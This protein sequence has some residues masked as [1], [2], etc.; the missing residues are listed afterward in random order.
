MA[1]CL[2][3][4]K[5]ESLSSEVEQALLRLS[6]PPSLITLDTDADLERMLESLREVELLIV[7]LRHFSVPPP[8]DL[9]ILLLTEA[10]SPP[11]PEPHPCLQLP[12]RSGDVT[13]LAGHLI[14]N[15]GSS[16]TCGGRED[17]S[18]VARYLREILHDLNNRQTTLQGNL[19]LLADSCQGEEPQHILSD[20][21]GAADQTERL[22]KFLEVLNPDTPCVADSLSLTD[23]LKTLSG[24]AK[25]ILPESVHFEIENPDSDTLLLADG[26]L[27]TYCLLTL[28]NEL[29]SSRSQLSLRIHPRE[30]QLEI[31]IDSPTPIAKM[32]EPTLHRM[33]Q[34]LQAMR[35]RVRVDEPRLILTLHK[36]SPSTHT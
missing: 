14:R 36:D 11:A 29:S 35:A 15:K 2:L 31:H 13:S 30:H 24:L 19:P 26:P 7:D 32:E 9:P 33:N 27:L 16:G 4:S 1:L 8:L 23:F 12:L 22:L 10:P 3:L 21:R 28:L 34:R 17:F 5:D 20:I 25:R 6:P 18:F